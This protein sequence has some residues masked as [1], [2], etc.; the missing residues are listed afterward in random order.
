MAQLSIAQYIKNMN[1]RQS[2]AFNKKTG[3]YWYNFEWITKEKLDEVLPIELSYA[4]NSNKIENRT[5]FTK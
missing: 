2:L 4:G 5:P 1:I 3:L